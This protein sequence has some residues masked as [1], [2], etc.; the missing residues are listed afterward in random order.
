MDT[1]FTT[2]ASIRAKLL[3][4]TTILISGLGFF[5]STAFSI[6]IPNLQQS[7]NASIDQI[8]WILG[9]YAITMSSLILVTGSLADQIGKKRTVIAGLT[10]FGV[11]SLVSL[12]ASSVWWLVVFRI[13]QGIGA[14]AII[15]QS[16]AL[17]SNHFT[18]DVRTQAIGIWSGL[19][20]A[21]TILGPALG[22]SLVDW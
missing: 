6:A 13:I 4:L 1:Q 2:F 10:L 15:P 7:F 17:L 9:A 12:F 19:A 18:K 16:L 11:G 14:A 20:G 22:G 8:Q 5:T 21:V 3:L